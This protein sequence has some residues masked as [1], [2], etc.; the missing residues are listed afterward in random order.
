L[1]LASVSLTDKVDGLKGGAADYLSKPVR[2]EELVMR[3]RALVRRSAGYAEPRITCG[4]LT[5]D[6]QTGVFELVLPG[7]NQTLPADKSS[8]YERYP[9]QYFTLEPS[10]DP[11]V[12]F[13]SHQLKRKILCLKR[14][15][16]RLPNTTNK[17]RKLIRMRRHNMAATIM[18]VES[19]NQ[20]RL[21][22]NLKLLMSTRHRLT[23]RA[24]SR[25]NSI[26]L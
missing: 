15:I 10:R 18:W 14:C 9:A 20:S 21:L 26:I 17:Q 13:L 1:A 25:S 6:A 3:L 2:I 24:N 4:P 11:S 12:G 5:F 7:S 19:S 23:T 8:I 16:R 22:K